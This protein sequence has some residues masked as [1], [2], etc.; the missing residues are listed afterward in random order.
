MF[1]VGSYYYDKHHNDV[2]FVK[3]VNAKQIKCFKFN[4]PN[5]IILYNKENAKKNLR[6]HSFI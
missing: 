2:L 5:Y 6:P 4:N 1:V 3:E